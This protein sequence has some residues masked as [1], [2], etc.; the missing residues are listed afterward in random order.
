MEVINQLLSNQT[1]YLNALR[2]AQQMPATPTPDP[3]NGP[4][5]KFNGELIFSIIAVAVIFYVGYQIYRPLI[6]E[7]LGKEE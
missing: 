7:S 6:R 1:D 5:F 4:R 2:H 3:G